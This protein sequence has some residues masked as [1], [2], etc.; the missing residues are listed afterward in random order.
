MGKRFRKK[1]HRDVVDNDK[2]T[3]AFVVQDKFTIKGAKNHLDLG[4]D[5]VDRFH[6]KR[7]NIEFDEDSA[8][9]D[10]VVEDEVFALNLKDSDESESED[11]ESD[12]AGDW[13]NTAGD[14]YDADEGEE[15]D[16]KL[17]EEEALRLQK[18]RA[19]ALS[20]EDF[21][22]SLPG[23]L[24]GKAIVKDDLED[25]KLVH[26]IDEQLKNL[27]VSG[28]EVIPK[29]HKTN[30]SKEKAL[31][32]LETE[33]PEVL[34]LSS[35]LK[36]RWEQVIL[37]I[38]P[39][40]L[41]IQSLKPDIVKSVPILRHVYIKYE[42]CL[43]YLTNIAFYLHLKASGA[44]DIQNH[45]II[46]SL[47]TYTNL[48]KKLEDAEEEVDDLLALVDEKLTKI[49]NGGNIH[50]EDEQDED[51]Q[52]A[53]LS[54]AMSEDSQALSELDDLD[55]DSIEEEP[56]SNASGGEDMESNALDSDDPKTTLAQ[57]RRNLKKSVVK[58]SIKKDSDF[59]DSQFLEEG[60]AIEKSARKHTLRHHASVIHQALDKRSHLHKFSG[61]ADLPYK[62]PNR[63]N[64]IP[65]NQAIN[66]ESNDADIFDD[67][68]VNTVVEA[69]P[70]RKRVRTLTPEE[71]AEIRESYLA[72]N[73]DEEEVGN[74]D[75][76]LASRKI[77]KNKGLAPKRKKEQRN[78][79]V[80]HRKKFEKATKKLSSFK[81]LVQKP[82]SNYGGESTGIKTHL[83]RSVHFQ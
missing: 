2:S 6:E 43:G 53:E 61:D 23:Q 44:T 37:V 1:G 29:T 54:E 78:P 27:D 77:L 75:K 73:P 36:E 56:I 13:G 10:D 76:R 4:L 34:E 79:R 74:S 39:L 47:V 40:A 64:K 52:E 49:E 19:M 67:D 14:Y 17:E 65:I 22:N 72:L 11:E 35:Q 7:E 20:E 26:S 38:H 82:T 15:D 30:L 3:S 66:K 16:N 12:N 69:G 46:E 5:E 63:Q 18:K 83:S 60:D 8:D 80:K 70:K 28:V 55:S 57:L 32:I 33:S 9:E 62:D 68:E 50:S 42:L 25:Q 48:L 51:L 21:L 31:D 81:R 41:R 45:P 59:L 71:V 24:S 58:S